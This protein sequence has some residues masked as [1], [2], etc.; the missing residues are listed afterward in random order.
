MLVSFLG[1]RRVLGD[2]EFPHFTWL[3]LSGMVCRACKVALG[4]ISAKLS[5]QGYV[6]QCSNLMTKSNRFAGQC[7]NKSLTS[8][9][10]IKQF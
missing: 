7:A 10:A 4:K 9:Q 3:F 2:I 6:N 1:G 8:L 5:F